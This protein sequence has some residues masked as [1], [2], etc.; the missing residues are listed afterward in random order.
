MGFVTATIVGVVLTAPLLALLYYL[1]RQRALDFLAVQLASIAAIY[2][3]SSLSS[4]GVAVSATE[5][6][7]FSGFVALALFGRWDA[8]ALLIAG[9]FAH[10]VWDIVHHVGAIQTY[11]P[12]WYGP[13]CLG[14]DFVMAAFVGAVFMR[15]STH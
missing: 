9:Y 7:A 15:S 4:G 10:G 5:I 13:L 3:G 14:Y 11:L 2:I 1:S 8:P 6:I 12:S